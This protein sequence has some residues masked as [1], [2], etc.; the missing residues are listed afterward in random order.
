MTIGSFLDLC[1]KELEKEYNDIKQITI[2][3]LMFVLDD[4][5]VPFVR[6]KKKLLYFNR[7]THFLN[8]LH[9]KQKEAGDY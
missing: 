5:I 7:A 1:K 3:G 4:C 9:L 8:F 2:E 6:I